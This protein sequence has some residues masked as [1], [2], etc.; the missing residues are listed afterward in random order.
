MVDG[1]ESKVIT[2]TASENFHFE[3]FE[4]SC[5][6]LEYLGY[7]PLSRLKIETTIEMSPEASQR[8]VAQKQAFIKKNDKD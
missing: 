2:H 1:G 6:P 5:P 4:E 3:E 8:Y 7:L